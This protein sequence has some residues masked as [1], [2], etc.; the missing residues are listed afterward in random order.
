MPWDKPESM[1]VMPATTDRAREKHRAETLS[2]Y[3][4]KLTKLKEDI[5]KLEQDKI[6]MDKHISEKLSASNKDIEARLRNVEKEEH[7]IT[8]IREQ[9]EIENEK[10]DAYF[11][12]KHNEL[13]ERLRLIVERETSAHRELDS[14][15]KL[16][17]KVRSFEVDLDKKK[18][19]LEEREIRINTDKE[20][21]KDDRLALDKVRAE[22]LS[23]RSRLD[24]EWDKIRSAEDVLKTERKIAADTKKESVEAVRSS[25]K[26]EEEAAIALEKV[27]EEKRKN[28]LVLKDIKERTE[29]LKTLS[30][31]LAAKEKELNELDKALIKKKEGLDKRKSVLDTIKVSGK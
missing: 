6:L 21:L 9:F 28:D 2:V 24:Q 4:S 15:G 16:K 30:L 7:R 27:L 14:V 8:K 29:S 17:Q 11:K 19:E 12:E 5:K 31:E 26:Q 25:K 23:L 20:R 22:N 18:K 13:D 1:A 10:R 3:S